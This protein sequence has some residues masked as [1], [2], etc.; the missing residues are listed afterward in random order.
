MTRS[1]RPK[2]NRWLYRTWAVFLGV[3]I[4]L[5]ILGLLLLRSTIHWVRSASSAPGWILGFLASSSEGRIVYYPLIA[6]KAAD[7][8]RIE[9]RSKT[10]RER[11][12]YRTGDPVEVLY[13]PSRPDEAV[14]RSF[15]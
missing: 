15:G 8:S 3:R 6:F 5:L 2:E 1:I 10:G 11:P 7:G 12:T 9:F 4:G 14:I 13:D